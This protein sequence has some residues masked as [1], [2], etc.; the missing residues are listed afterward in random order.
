[1]IPTSGANISE[2]NFQVGIYLLFPYK[3]LIMWTFTC[4]DNRNDS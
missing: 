2:I 1:M 4:N 3:I